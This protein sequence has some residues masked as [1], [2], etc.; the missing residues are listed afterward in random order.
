MIGNKVLVPYPGTP[1]FESPWRH[2]ME[3]LH[4]NWS[5]YDRLSL[6][7]YRLANL[8]EYQ[9]YF[10]FLT[11]ESILLQ[12]YE[13]RIANALH[14]A[15]APPESLDYVYRCYVQQIGPQAELHREKVAP[16]I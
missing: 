7:V 15:Q 13:T 6:P 3:L 10:G 4:Q 1:Y 5:K 11:L 2:Q 8:T 9:I 16:L 12:A 14:I